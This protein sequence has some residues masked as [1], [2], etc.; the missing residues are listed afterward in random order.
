MNKLSSAIALSRAG[1]GVGAIALLS[2]CA[3]FSPVTYDCSNLVSAPEVGARIVMATETGQPETARLNGV[4]AICVDDDE[5]VD[6]ELAIGLKVNR[7]LQEGGGAA[8]LEVPFIAAIIDGQETVAAHE[9]FSFRMAFG[10]KI[11]VLYPLVRQDISLP[12]DGRLVISL[13]PEAIELN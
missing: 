1:M 8:L 7:S 6:I 11:D 5:M 9:S 13:V 4:T 12:K 2:A 3:S 10:D